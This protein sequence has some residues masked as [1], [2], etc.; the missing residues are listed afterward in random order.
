MFQFAF[1]TN[2]ARFQKDDSSEKGINV[3][4]HVLWSLNN[5]KLGYLIIPS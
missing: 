3:K 4:K 5:F 1:K 2:I